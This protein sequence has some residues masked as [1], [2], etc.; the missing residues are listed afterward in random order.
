MEAERI[1]QT[2]A[3]E[4]WRFDRHLRR[5]LRQEA[6]GA[7]TPVPIGSRALE[8]L[9]VLLEQP[10]ALVS[11][12]AIMD[13]V[14][15]AA[16]V[17][18][19]NLT[20]QISALRQVLDHGR[21]EGSC[22]QTVAGRGYRFVV[23][24]LPPESAPRPIPPPPPDGNAGAAVPASEGGAD[25]GGPGA[26]TPLVTHRGPATGAMTPSAD[27]GVPATDVTTPLVNHGGPATGTM[28]P[29]ADLGV[30]P[31]GTRPPV[32]AP[33]S[34]RLVQSWRRGRIAVL[35]IAFCVAIGVLLLV[36]RGHHFWRGEP[37]TRP[38]LSLVV[39]PFE[40]LGGDAKDD[41]LADG[42]TD[43]L[44]S[45]LSHITGAF[46][47]ARQ[48]AYSYKGKPEDVRKIGT[49]LGVRYVIEGSV[50]RIGAALMVNVRLTSAETGAELWS[51]RFDEQVAELAAGQEPIVARMR[52]ELGISIIDIESARSLRDRPTD[53]DAFDLVLRAR[54]LLH[55]PPGP[56]QYRQTRAL[57]EQALARDPSSVPATL[58]LG[59]AL[60]LMAQN[61]GSW[62]TAED[63]RHAEK[64]LTQAQAAGSNTELMFNLRVQWLQAQG[65]FQD[66]STIAK[67]LIERFPNDESGYFDLAQNLT[68]LGR[69]AE[70][71]PLE[72]K[73]IQVNPRSSWIFA[74]YRDMGYALL[75][76][77]RDQDA[78]DYLERSLALNLV[79]S[80]FRA[81]TYRRLAAAYARTGQLAKARE[82]V[83]A[84]DRLWPYETVRMHRQYVGASFVSDHFPDPV[85]AEQIGRYQDAVRLAGE[86]DHADEDADFG[87]PADAA[88]HDF[89]GLTPMS[90]P[91]VKT[92]RT[93][94]L[95]RYLAQAH[96]V[97]IDTVSYPWGRSIP[98][99][100]GLKSAG[101][102]GSVTDVAQTE[103]RRAVQALTHGDVA[104]PIVAV[105]W[106]AER[107]DGRNLALRLAA[108]GYTQVYWYRGGREAWEAADM[109]ET[110]LAVRDW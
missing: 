77:G 99:A 41:Y 51:D 107:F 17:E 76:L 73:A 13:A 4:G 40:N 60:L 48:S 33:G 18:P 59:M 5:L 93:A 3:F 106:N 9:A 53:P 43:D 35:P 25:L 49:D 62:A 38:R 65:R 10:G 21:T 32:G 36:G 109:P 101:V 15:P 92:I 74:R 104:T 94:D 70:A 45:D 81:M 23:P 19:N 58:G 54:S 89:V 26:M 108:L 78:I 52:T 24:I 88:L 91:G 95:A 75:L 87:V 55:Q 57:Y 68:A 2:L 110:E 72:E 96:P 66:S 83:A 79:D 103:L 80:R 28:T 64:L 90:A 105:G 46:V 16:S 67:E 11:K 63:M 56:Q 12:D 97:V 44:T 47:I 86:R 50:R 8:I 98:G 84:A 20:V 42:I 34:S 37:P 14:W 82:D 1:S 31:T 71:I 100:I 39:L 7:W 27:R 85:F 22:I 102:G 6:G 30:P 61:Q 69:A 29:S